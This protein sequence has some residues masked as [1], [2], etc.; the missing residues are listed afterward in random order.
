MST[1]NEIVRRSLDDPAA[2]GELFDRHAVAIHR[3]V[4]RRTDA[5][6]ADDVVSTTFLVAFE[7]RGGYQLDRET[8][9]PWLFG[10]ATNLVRRHRRAE[11]RMLRA[12]QRAAERDEHAG[13]TD[14][15]DD[16]LDA[17]R[18]LA[19]LASSLRTLPS[20]QRDVLLLHAWA[21]LSYQ[22]IAEALEV[23]V[24]TVRSRLSRARAAMHDAPPASAAP[25]VRPH[26]TP[27]PRRP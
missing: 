10:I 3:Y 16:R 9:A 7:R 20:A 11:V 1:D 27:A 2:F 8:A 14:R 15:V 6:V 17:G 18:A 13:A 5:G 26:P 24:G 4:A 25:L 21:D 22:Q 19:E 23:P 12:L